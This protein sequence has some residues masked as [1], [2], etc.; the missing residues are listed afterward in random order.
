MT[1]ILIFCAQTSVFANEQ[2]FQLVN[3]SEKNIF[4]VYCSQVYNENWEENL[5][6]NDI[7]EDNMAVNIHFDMFEKQQFW[8]IR[9]VYEGGS[10]V[11]WRNIDLFKIQKITVHGDGSTEF[12]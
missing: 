1:T 2:D 6:G 11:I 10:E 4:G 3:H 5:L 12:L 7:L 9:I 8:D